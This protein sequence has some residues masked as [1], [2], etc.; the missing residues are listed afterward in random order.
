MFLFSIEIFTSLSYSL[1]SIKNLLVFL[2]IAREKFTICCKIFLIHCLYQ[3][4]LFLFLRA[5]F[6]VAVI[7]Y[8]GS[9]LFVLCG[10]KGHKVFKSYIF[11]SIFHI[12]KSTMRWVEVRVHVSSNTK[13][14][15]KCLFIYMKVCTFMC[16]AGW[17]YVW[18]RY[19]LIS[20]NIRYCYQHVHGLSAT[21]YFCCHYCWT[22]NNQTNI[23][24][25]TFILSFCLYFLCDFFFYIFLF[26]FF[27]LF[28]QF[29]L[30][31]CVYNKNCYFFREVIVG[32]CL[33]TFMTCFW[34]GWMVAKY[35]W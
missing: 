26:K 3:Y 1:E 23:L 20:L 5:D 9:L 17:M 4:E 12:G 28:L 8:F 13:A 33:M 34:M 22:K 10:K 16:T 11:G 29:C 30:F 24:N 19:K 14:S 32:F 27:H 2:E 21:T 31:V 18:C 7:C 35:S 6:V 25:F 15:P